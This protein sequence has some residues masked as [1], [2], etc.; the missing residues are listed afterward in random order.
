[1]VIAE[2]SHT[3]HGL[4]EELLRWLCARFAGRAE[5]FIETI[6]VPKQFGP[7]PCG[8]YGPSVGDEPVT[9]G[10]M[11]QRPG[12]RYESHLVKRPTRPTRVLTVVAGPSGDK[13]CVLYTAYAGPQAPQEP[14]DPRCRDLEASTAFWRDHALCAES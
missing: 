9:D 11:A 2:G 3:D 13:P 12:R 8:I 6:E 14:A 7:M 1:M 4:S 10:F 5:F